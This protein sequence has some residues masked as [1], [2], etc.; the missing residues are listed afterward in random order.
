MRLDRVVM[1]TNVSRQN[2]PFFDGIPPALLDTRPHDDKDIAPGEVRAALA[3]VLAGA[4][5]LKARRTSRL[6]EFLVEKRLA[7]ALRDTNEFTIG[8]EVFER[9]PATFDPG[10]DPVVRVQVGRLRAKLKNYY[11]TSGPRPSIVFAIPVGSYMP[12]ICRGPG[13]G[14]EQSSDGNADTLRLALLPLA[15]IP[16]SEICSAFAHGLRE[17]LTFRLFQDFGNSLVSTPAHAGAVPGLATGPTHLLEGSVRA[18]GELIRLGLRVVDVATGALA[19]SQQIDRRVPFSIGL[20]EEL[21]YHVSSAL[22]RHFL[23]D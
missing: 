3:H 9:N 17:E 2:I 7:N 11:G 12:V 14:V 13:C 19:W 21:G 23:P 16:A 6:L 4:E 1:P 20:Q 15:S 5:F 10:A 22:K 8:I 18:E